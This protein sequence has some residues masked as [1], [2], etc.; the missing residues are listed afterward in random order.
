MT[1]EA[2]ATAV[3]SA[4]TVAASRHPSLRAAYT[5]RGPGSR[6]GEI[7]DA[8]LAESEEFTALW[9]RHEIGVRRPDTKRFA[10][11]DLGILELQCQALLDPG[12][13][14]SSSST[15]PPR[16]P[17]ATTNSSCSPSSGTGSP[18]GEE[19]S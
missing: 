16:A 2:A 8:L 12:Q 17:T 10:H 5:R 6:A 4:A 14:R 18:T 1:D 11:P 7:T 19:D 9:S 3:G 15:P 13:T